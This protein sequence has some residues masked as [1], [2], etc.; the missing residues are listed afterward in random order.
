M[1]VS[2]ITNKH[3]IEYCR[4]Y[5]ELTVLEKDLLDTFLNSAKNYI[6]NYTALKDED[7]EQHEE[8]SP[9]V[10]VLVEDMWDNRQLYINGSGGVRPYINNVVESVLDMHRKNLV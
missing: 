1:K 10:F 2:E 9:V 7:I 4:I 5:D 3:L 8:F 6:K